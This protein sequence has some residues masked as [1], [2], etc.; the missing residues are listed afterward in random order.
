MASTSKSEQSYIRSSLLANPPLRPDGRSLSDYRPIS[1]ETK[2]SPLANGSA[3]VNIGGLSLIGVGGSLVGTEVLAAVKAEVET[4][5]DGGENSWG[6]MY[7]G[8]AEGSGRI[9]CNVTR[10]IRSININA[11][12]VPSGFFHFASSFVEKYMQQSNNKFEIYPLNSL[13]PSFPCINVIQIA[14]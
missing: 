13:L 5:A 8:N 6:S 12:F 1:L 2:V 7:G 4:L 3:R 9:A 14:L 10:Y 11:L